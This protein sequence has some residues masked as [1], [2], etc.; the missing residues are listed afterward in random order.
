MN[1]LPEQESW[2]LSTLRSYAVLNS[3]ADPALDELTRL[4]ARLCGTPMAMITLLTEDRLWCLSRAGLGADATPL[5]PQFCRQTLNQPGIFTL[6]DSSTDARWK[7]N[8]LITGLPAWR[9]YAGAPLISPEGAA[10]GTLCVLDHEPRTLTPFQEESLG[11]LGRQVMALLELRRETISR[12]AS[13]ADRA[14]IM[15]CSFDAIIIIDQYGLIR[16]FNPAAEQIFQ[17]RRAEVVGRSLTETIVPPEWREQHRAGLNRF[18]QSNQSSVFGKR[19]EMTAIRGAGERFAVELSLVRSPGDGSPSFIGF[20][21]DISQQQEAEQAAVGIAHLSPTGQY[22]RVNDKLCSILGFSRQEML[23]KTFADL[24]L[25]ENLETAGEVRHELLSGSRTS[26]SGELRYRR[27][28]GQEVWL[29]HVVTLER[30][31]TG[32]PKYFITVYQEITAR[33]LAEFRLHR[34]NRLHTVLSKTSE[35][36]V[37]C[38]SRQ[39]LY[40][41]FCRILVQDG[42][43]RMSYIA[44]ID[45]DTGFVQPLAGCGTGLDY[46]NC[47]LITTDGGPRSQG[48][49]GTACRTGEYDC[50]NDFKDDPRMGPWRDNA[51]KHGF[52]ATA[53]FPIKPQGKT[54]GVLAL[55]ASEVNYFQ[56]DEIRLMVAVANNLSFA[57]EVLQQEDQRQRA[58]YALRISEANMAAAQRLARFGNWE[59]T[60]ATGQLQWSPVIYTIFGLDPRTDLPSFSLFLSVIPDEDRTR[61]QEAQAHALAT[62]GKLDVEHRLIRPDGS[63]RW[64][65]ELGQAEYDESGQPVRLTGTVLDITHRKRTE[66]RMRRLFE[67]NVQGVYFWKLDGTISQANDAFLAMTGYTRNDF[68]QG[69]LNWRT[70][71]PPEFDA[72]DQAGRDAM[73]ASGYCTPFEKEYLRKDGTRLPV[74]IG[75]AS[76]DDSPD[77]GVCFVLDLT[78]RKQ[79]EQQFLRSQRMESIGTLAGGIAHDLNNALGPILLSLDILRTRYP[80]PA[81]K[82]LLDIIHQSAQRGAD[83]VRQLLSFARGVEGHQVEVQTSHLVE[84]ISRIANETFL[85]HIKVRTQIQADLWPV[86]GDPTQLHQV[87]LNL[88]VNARDA[89]S[90]GGTLTLSAANVILD[91]HYSSL[92][93]DARPGSWLHLKVEDTGSGMAPEIIEKIFDPFFTTKPLGE[94]TGLG[95]STSLGIIKSHHGFLRVH[96]TPGTGTTFEIYLPALTGSTAPASPS[97]PAVLP[98]GHQELILVVDD[99]L[100]VRQITQRTLEAHGYRVLQAADGAEAIAIFVN[101]RQ[102]IAAVLTDMMM[103][104]MDGPATIRVL[105]RLSP[106]LPIIAASGLSEDH[107]NNGTTTP[108][109]RHFLPKPYTAEALLNALHDVLPA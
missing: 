49:V 18:L 34:L 103:P 22:I 44:E 5:D 57:L 21:R 25:E 62:R 24:S 84:E 52:L 9:F 72:A 53:A 11:V 1:V 4:A 43:L 107:R 65:H 40:E 54:T 86:L 73:A 85:K 2:R 97:A 30:S 87:L 35:A 90:E 3:V 75:F 45:P 28:D 37:R 64:V 61:L 36:V 96:S 56:E 7:Q 33:K 10:L 66:S 83:M 6:T 19:L 12:Q 98:R 39:E 42:L 27:K 17:R 101:R 81:S 58:E 48:P 59:H 23:Q 99:E 29:H 16:E 76:F 67:S 92:N 77:E 82:E 106:L 95:L 74:L 93:P 13:E 104:I 47:L 88:C 20:L 63:I 51:L 91:S 68:E 71:T 32:T 69:L 26:H 38:R 31:A 79:L 14:N 8:P 102:E 55:Y 50:C 60:L 109:I 89:M 94:G 78:T 15:A 41:S 80:D 108:G 70:M 105:H 46:L 100:T